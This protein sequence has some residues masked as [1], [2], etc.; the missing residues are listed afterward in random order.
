MTGILEIVIPLA[1]L[2]L[3]A[4]LTAR[5][6]HHKLVRALIASPLYDKLLEQLRER[7]E[8]SVTE[9]VRDQLDNAMEKIEEETNEKIA[10]AIEDP[11]EFARRVQSTIDK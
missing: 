9:A 7:L 4:L 6:G 8:R 3:L 2:A 1:A 5:F 10:Q 11:S